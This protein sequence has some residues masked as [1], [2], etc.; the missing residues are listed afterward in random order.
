MVIAIVTDNYFV[1]FVVVF[2]TFVL[3]IIAFFKYRYLYWKNCGIPTCKTEFF[4]GSIKDVVFGKKPLSI[5]M[6]E[7]YDEA[8]SRNLPHIGSFYIALPIYNAVDPDIIKH[9]LQ[10]DFDVFTNRGVYYNERDDPL[11]AN[12]FT[13]ESKKWRNLRQKLSPTFTSGQMKYMFTTLLE[14]SDGLTKLIDEHVGNK[15]INIKEAMARYSTDVIASCAF[16]ITCDTF[17]NPDNEFRKCGKQIFEADLENF[18]RRTVSQS[19][20]KELLRRLGFLFFKSKSTKF[21]RKVVNDTVSYRELNDVYR[22]DFMQLLLQIKNKDTLAGTE[23]IDYKKDSSL[24]LTMDELAAQAF[25][26]YLA[27][28][29]TS[30]TA[31]SYVMY[32]LALNQDIQDK[33]RQEIRDVLKKYGEEVTY[34]A[35]IEMKYMQQVIDGKLT[36]F[37]FISTI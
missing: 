36:E 17:T 23:N 8:R 27:G 31:A 12:L 11:S 35:V 18:I 5:I 37:P 16:G 13:L 15:A 20:S 21:F 32:E 9:I 30:S 24:S 26:F 28:F 6:K 2:A 7:V 19:F 22:K 34:D 14:K 29:E 3:G 25:L 4:W 33:V 10:V 1:T